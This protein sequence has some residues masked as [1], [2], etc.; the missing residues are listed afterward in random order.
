MFRKLLKVLHKH[1][2]LLT[3]DELLANCQHCQP[4]VCWF[5]FLMFYD[6]AGSDLAVEY[7][8]ILARL[9]LQIPTERLA[10]IASMLNT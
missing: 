2:D 3:E 8:L 6:E 5:V 1:L 10:L 7:C 4:Q 9:E